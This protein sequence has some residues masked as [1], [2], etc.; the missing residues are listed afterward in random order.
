MGCIVSL[1]IH[2]HYL[3][4]F[5]HPHVVMDSDVSQTTETSR[6]QEGPRQEQDVLDIIYIVLP[7]HLGLGHL[8]ARS[9]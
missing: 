6:K 1:H 2:H 5:I 9:K 4:L 3:T 8:L 7:A